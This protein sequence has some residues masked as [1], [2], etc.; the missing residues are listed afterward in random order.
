[1]PSENIY[2][3]IVVDEQSLTPKYLQLTNSV[4]KAI[5][6]GK[7]EKNYILPS[8]N[9]VSYELD[10]SRDTAD[11]AYRRLKKKVFIMSC[12]FSPPSKK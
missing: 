8:I 2:R 4:I 3:Y 5:E 10:I 9:E 6:S 11:R 12:A 1:M 7:I